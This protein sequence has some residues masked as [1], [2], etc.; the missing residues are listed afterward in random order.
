MDPRSDARASTRSA[1]PERPTH[2][3]VVAAAM[4]LGITLLLVLIAVLGTVR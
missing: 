4:M 1:S 2:P 3:T